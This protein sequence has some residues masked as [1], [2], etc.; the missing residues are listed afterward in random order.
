V[1]MED[2][3][4]RA[5]GRRFLEQNKNAKT[6]LRSVSEI[7]EIKKIDSGYFTEE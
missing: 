4:P 6:W 5:F 3:L 2:L 7:Y 1:M